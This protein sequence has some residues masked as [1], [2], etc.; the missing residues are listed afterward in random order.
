MSAERT[1][2]GQGLWLQ[3]VLASMLG[4]A[5]GATIGNAVATSLP[6]MTCTQSSSDSLFDR[7]TNF[8]CLLPSLGLALVL[9]V[10]GLAGGFTQWLVLRR[11][12]AGTGWWMPANALGFPIALV[13]AVNTGTSLPGDSIAAPILIGVV[14]GLL[15]GIM[16][17][18]I[19][20]RQLARAGWW[21]PAHMLGSLV[22]GAMGI[23]AFHALS[24]IGLYQFDW[25]A[26]GALFGAGLGAIT[27]VTLNWLVRQVTVHL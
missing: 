25:A 4:F 8:P 3:W 5:V 26:A 12:I 14:F 16:P 6:P 10:L 18:L 1:N 24:L 7:L 9:T 27:G 23:V 19:L 22:G 11:R 20:R 17:W 13:I 21:I 2:P 15:S